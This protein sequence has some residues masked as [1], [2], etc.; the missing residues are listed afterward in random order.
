MARKSDYG[1][2]NVAFDIDR[3]GLYR[4]PTEKRRFLKA[5]KAKKAQKAARRKNRK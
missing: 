1:R 4:T 5:V 3:H 2:H